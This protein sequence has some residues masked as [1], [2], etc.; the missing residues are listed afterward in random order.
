[1]DRERAACGRDEEGHS[2]AAMIE[3]MRELVDSS[4]WNQYEPYFLSIIFGAL[5]GIERV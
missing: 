2:G 1:M 5:V 3:F 4:V